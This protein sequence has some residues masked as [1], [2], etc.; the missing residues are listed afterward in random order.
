MVK[1]AEE[2]RLEVK[3][4]M[5]SGEG[6][7]KLLHILEREEYRG[8]SRLI[9]K[10]ILEPNCSIGW[11]KH[12]NEEEIFYLLSGKAVFTDGET[13]KELLPGDACVTLGGEG[14]SIANKGQETVELLAVIL[15][16]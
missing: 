11:H 10:I 13:E 1:K 6:S 8:N 3:E 7:V 12:E 14:H 16:Y 15:N 5:R 2:M 4:R 9:A